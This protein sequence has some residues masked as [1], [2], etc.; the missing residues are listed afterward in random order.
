MSQRNK[1]LPA[2]QSASLEIQ[3]VLDYIPGNYTITDK[4]DGERYFL[5][6][7]DNSARRSEPPTVA[8]LQLHDR[9]AER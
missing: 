6:I 1:D 8:P 3:H 7:Q 9:E 4:A 5:I 2:M